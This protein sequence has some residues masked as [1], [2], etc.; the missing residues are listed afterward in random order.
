[1]DIYAKIFLLQIEGQNMSHEYANMRFLLTSFT[2][3]LEP[4]PYFRP[5]FKNIN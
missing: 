1:M 3:K 5:I 4:I 2:S